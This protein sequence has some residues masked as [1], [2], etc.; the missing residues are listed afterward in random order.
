MEKENIKEQ[1]LRCR[2]MF[3]NKVGFFGTHFSG[4]D[5]KGTYDELVSNIEYFVKDL[6]SILGKSKLYYRIIE[7][8]PCRYTFFVCTGNG[9]RSDYSDERES[10]REYYCDDEGEEDEDDDFGIMSYE[11]YKKQ[12]TCVSI[13]RH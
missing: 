6:G 12:F 5:Y 3:L 8:R 11:D 1:L 7:E 9:I 4:I 2:N 10:L 13:K